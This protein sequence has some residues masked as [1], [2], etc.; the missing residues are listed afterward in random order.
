MTFKLKLDMVKVNNEAIN[1][2]A[3]NHFV[4]Q[5]LCEHARTQTCTHS[6]PTAIPRPHQSDR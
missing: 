3:K 1:V 2:E 5:L 4:R 6:G